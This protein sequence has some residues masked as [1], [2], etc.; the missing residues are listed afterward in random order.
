MAQ[1]IFEGDLLSTRV[2]IV[3]LD[4][5]DRNDDPSV[6]KWCT[7]EERKQDSMGGESWVPI[8]DGRRSPLWIGA[9]EVF[10]QGL[11]EG[12][13]IVAR[14]GKEELQAALSELSG[15][16]ATALAE[17]EEKHQKEREEFIMDRTT[18]ADGHSKSVAELEDRI[19]TLEAQL[20]Q[21]DDAPAH[22]SVALDQENAAAGEQM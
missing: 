1:K 22:D 11:M 19:A 8:A 5:K 2:R 4:E 6:M 18:T 14:R 21:K 17:L 20:R 3:M 13:E 15:T 12:V 16:H 9:F 10:T 7:V